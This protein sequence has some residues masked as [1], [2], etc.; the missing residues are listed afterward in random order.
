[1]LI[2]VPAVEND[3]RVLDLCQPVVLDPGPH[4]VLSSP[5]LSDLHLMKFTTGQQEIFSLGK[6]RNLL[7]ARFRLQGAL[8]WYI[9]RTLNVNCELL[10]GTNTNLSSIFFNSPIFELSGHTGGPI[11]PP[12]CLDPTDRVKMWTW[13][14]IYNKLALKLISD[15]NSVSPC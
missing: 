6:F 12:R 15:S 10:T 5:L 9:A 8:D 2:I 4:C 14:C 3:L 13:L 1:M 11:D 7:N